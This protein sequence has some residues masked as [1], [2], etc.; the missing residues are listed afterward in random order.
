MNRSLPQTQQLLNVTKKMFSFLCSLVSTDQSTKS[1]KTTVYNV[2]INMKIYVILKQA[3]RKEAVPKK[4]FFHH[5]FKCKDGA[6]RG[7]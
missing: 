2:L 6:L 1:S 7:Q 4:I 3:L 5:S